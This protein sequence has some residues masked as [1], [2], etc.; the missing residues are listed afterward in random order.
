MLVLVHNSPDQACRDLLGG[1]SALFQ[2]LRQFPHPFCK[3]TNILVP[4][5][6]LIRDRSFRRNGEFVSKPSEQFFEP[7]SFVSEQ[8]AFIPQVVCR[9]K[10]AGLPRLCS[11]LLMN[12]EAD[13]SCHLLTR[14]RFCE[15]FMVIHDWNEVSSDTG[16]SHTGCQISTVAL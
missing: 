12:N 1:E 6:C 4:K 11:D 10:K 5:N 13:V 9:R 16:F 3:R 7:L 8:F 15:V 2:E 14:K